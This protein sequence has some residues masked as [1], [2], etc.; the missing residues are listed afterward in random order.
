M[1]RAL[2]AMAPGAAAGSRSLWAAGALKRSAA[3]AVVELEGPTRGSLGSA[4][5]CRATASRQRPAAAAPPPDVVA[6]A[7][8]C[9]PGVGTATSSTAVGGQDAEWWDLRCGPAELRPENVL[10]PGQSFG[11]K[12]LS[13]TDWL[14]TLAGG[15]VVLVRQADQTTLVRRIAGTVTETEVRRYFGLEVPGAD[16]AKLYETWSAGC[17]R[18]AE[19]AKCVAGLRVLQQDPVEIVFSF[20]CSQNNNVAR[21]SLLLDRL[22][23]ELG[24]LLCPMPPGLV[25][26]DD[27]GPPAA[28]AASAPREL[29]HVREFNA[30]GAVHGFPTLEA[31]AGAEEAT[32]QRLGL[33]YRAAYV[34]NGAK[35]VLERGG[36][37][38]LE[39]LRGMPRLEVQRALCELPGVGP[40]VADCIAL[41]AL[42][43]HGVIPVDVHV[44][45]ITTRDYEPELRQAKSLT[46][47]VYEQVGDAFRKRFGDFA[48]WAHSLL[49][50]AELAGA[51]RARLPPRLLQEMDAFREE[52]K[53]AAKELKERRRA[54]TEE[55]KTRKATA[56]APSDGAAGA[57]KAAK[58]PKAP[59]AVK[60]PKAGEGAALKRPAGRI[61]LR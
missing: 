31:L 42:E 34:R 38:W 54:G 48:G 23:A 2:R 17:P 45:R 8:T 7:A 52:E 50:G 6:Y 21:I 44:W 32:L 25:A 60:G 47:R 51:A 28:D 37:T 18:L 4:V 35:A 57:S 11:W 24:P 61:D 26:I 29:A 36:R 46:P 19:V 49:F 39:S 14:G 53:R 13:A 27:A 58:S 3:V 16:L 12:R 41:F 40:K 9:G 33:G 59:K 30:L 56:T 1:L 55:K 43:Q 5:A 15:G 22:R 10:T 20:I